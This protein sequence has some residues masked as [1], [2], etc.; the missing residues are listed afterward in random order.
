[1]EREETISWSLVTGR[2]DCGSSFKNFNVWSSETV[3]VASGKEG[4]SMV[5][6]RQPNQSWVAVDVLPT[7]GDGEDWGWGFWEGFSSR[8]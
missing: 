1:M 7:G 4:F 8:W 6:G 2:N 5:V 3:N